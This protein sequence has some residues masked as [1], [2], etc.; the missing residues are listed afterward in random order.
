MLAAARQIL[1]FGPISAAT[2]MQRVVEKRPRNE[3][4]I[5]LLRLDLQVATRAN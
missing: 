4:R 3:I 1:N 2:K 5:L